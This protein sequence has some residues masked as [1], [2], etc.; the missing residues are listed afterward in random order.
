VSGVNVESPT[1]KAI[2]AWA[3]AELEELRDMLEQPRDQAD[4]QMLRGRAA[5]ARRL[6]D[7][8]TIARR[9]AM[10]AAASSPRQVFGPSFQPYA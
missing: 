7:L 9:A 10:D 6:L 3:K 4:T 2:E 5:Q 1:W 8:A